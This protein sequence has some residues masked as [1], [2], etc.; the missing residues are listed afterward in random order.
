RSLVEDEWRRWR[1]KGDWAQFS[2]LL[3][4]VRE[5]GLACDSDEH[6]AGISALGG[7][8]RDRNGEIHAISVPVPSQRFVQIRPQV[9]EAL[10]E[11]LKVLEAQ[12]SA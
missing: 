1:H 5:T 3:A 6:T 7:A 8:F 11:T 9:E 12:L 4:R 10:S 2:G